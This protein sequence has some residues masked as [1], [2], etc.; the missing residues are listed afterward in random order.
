MAAPAQGA[1]AADAFFFVEEAKWHDRLRGPLSASRWVAYASATP[2]PRLRLFCFPHAGSGTAAY[3]AWA[4]S[5]PPDV[6]LALVQLPGREARMAERPFTRM[7]DLVAALMPAL[8]PHLDVD[9]VF[10]G[11]SMGAHVAFETARALAAEGLS[12]RHLVVSGNRAPRL[13]FPRA[14]I[15]HEPDERVLAEFARLGGTPRDVL[16]DAQL[17]SLLL[18][19]L[20]ADLEL[21]ETYAYAPGPPLDLPLT[22]LGGAR[23]PDVPIEALE[24]WRGETRGPFTL[25]LFDGGHFFLYEDRARVLASISEALRATRVAET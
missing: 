13:P 15:H 9:F 18:P 6:Q 17:M 16:A 1:I 22:V 21:C 25:R 7:R 8:R 24:A 14:R 19:I 20:R 5:L 3:R 23:D 4:G 12:P 2:A 11:H 10:F